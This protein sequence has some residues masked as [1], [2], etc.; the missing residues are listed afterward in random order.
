[1]LTAV[2]PALV[3]VVVLLVCAKAV[4][5]TAQAIPVANIFINLV[6]FMFVFAFGYTDALRCEFIRLDPARVYSTASM[7]RK[8]WPGW[9]HANEGV[10]H[11]ELELNAALT[12]FS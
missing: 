9:L 4:A 1:V 6:C 2:P 11:E 8:F 3:V 7:F 12:R 10:G 5:A